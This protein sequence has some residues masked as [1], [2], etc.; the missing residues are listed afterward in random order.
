LSYRGYWVIE[1]RVIE[2]PLYFIFYIGTYI[3]YVHIYLY[4]VC[5]S[6][7]IKCTFY[8]SLNYC[9]R[10]YKTPNLTYQIKWFF[11]FLFVYAL[12][13]F[14]FKL[15]HCVHTSRYKKIKLHIKCMV[16][17][18]FFFFVGENWFWTNHLFLVSILTLG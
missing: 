15:Y 17:I 4:F 16:F 7:I 10:Q 1:V 18:R 5:I 3:I 11:I 2:T 6:N 8:I 14:H 13:C 12:L 9:L